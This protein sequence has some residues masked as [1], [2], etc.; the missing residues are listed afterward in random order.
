MRDIY[1]VAEPKKFP[2]CDAFV[3]TCG[4]VLE[5]CEVRKFVVTQ[6]VFVP[7]RWFASQ[8]E[9][10]SEGIH[11]GKDLNQSDLKCAVHDAKNADDFLRICSKFCDL[12]S[13]QYRP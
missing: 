5:F 11:L 1:L 12:L 2:F 10:D 6:A 7:R 8:N 3:L 4:P 9:A 13:S